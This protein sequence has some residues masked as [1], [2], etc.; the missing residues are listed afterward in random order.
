MIKTI[1][2]VVFFKGVSLMENTFKKNRLAGMILAVLTG[3]AATFSSP[4]IS[5]DSANFDLGVIRTGK[6]VSA[7]HAFKI[8]NTGDSV[9]IIKQVKPG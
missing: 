8:K 4:E 3:T 9:L 7:K 6:V 2:P 1:L 5:V